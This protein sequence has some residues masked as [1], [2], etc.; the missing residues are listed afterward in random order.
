MTKD[1]KYKLIFEN[2]RKFRTISEKEGFGFDQGPTKEPLQYSTEFDVKP[3]EEEEEEEEENILQKFKNKFEKFKKYFDSDSDKKDK[4]T[5]NIK[6]SKN[7]T[8][9]PD[10]IYPIVDKEAK[11][12]NIDTSVMMSLINTE[13]TFKPG[14]KSH[15]GALGLTQLK[16]GTAKE[17]GVTDPLDI[18]QSIEGG[19]KYMRTLIDKHIPDQMKIANAKIDYNKLTE[20]QKTFLALYAYHMGA[21]GLARK[22]KN[23][24]NYEEAKSRMSAFYKE[25]GEDDYAVKTMKNTVSFIRTRP[26]TPS[27]LSSR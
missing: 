21:A 7:K 9:S 14:A 15:K 18:R 27:A 12:Y 2:W 1:D 26:Q 13:S 8:V 19:T 20:K 25:I 11:K 17:M 22:I 10:E 16:P 3:E 5:T 24:R 4:P 23:S 6:L